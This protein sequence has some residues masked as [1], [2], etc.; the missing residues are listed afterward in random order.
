MA[1]KLHGSGHFASALFPS[2][3]EDL[4]QAEIEMSAMNYASLCLSVGLGNAIAMGLLLAF[5]GAALGNSMLLM[6]TLPLAI[7]LLLVT[8]VTLV[9][10]PRVI[11]S[12]RAR[13]LERELIPALQQML[14]EI[15]SGVTL[16]NA[17]ASVSQDY[18]EVSREFKKVVV[19]M[20]AGEPELDALSEITE[21]N[22]SKSFK[23][24]LWQVSNALKVGS[25]LSGVLDNQ[26]N[27][28]TRERIDQI[29]RYGQELSPWTMMYMM[30]A[31]ILPSI[32]VSMMIVIVGFMSI[33]LPKTVL[34]GIRLFL[35]GFQLFFMNLVASR[36]PAV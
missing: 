13:E 19:K 16:F 33:P 34:Y 31:V 26:V 12:R 18:G 11:A 20:N 28:L 6:V 22:P 24:V 32:G 17:M 7:G 14:I 23:K 9:Y 25:D 21:A 10:Y 2:L 4:C 30:V 3:R 35:T 15:K 1:G 29:R 27:S 36:R 5:L 8:F